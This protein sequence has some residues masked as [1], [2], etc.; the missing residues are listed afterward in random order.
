MV[1]ELAAK[2]M[3]ACEG[4]LLTGGAATPPPPQPI[5]TASIKTKQIFRTSCR[6]TDEVLAQTMAH[7]H[8][9]LLAEM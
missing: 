7:S 6:T 8:P 4:P 5:R 3:T 1:L 2:A 9:V